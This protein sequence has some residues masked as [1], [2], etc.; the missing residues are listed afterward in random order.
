MWTPALGRKVGK[1]IMGEN[2][3][4]VK[5][6]SEKLKSL[7]A[8]R[9]LSCAPLAII[10]ILILIST[11]SSVSFNF[12]AASRF[13]Q[14]MNYTMMHVMGTLV[15]LLTIPS[16]ICLVIAL[17]FL[18]CARKKV[19]KKTLPFIVFCVIGMAFSALFS[20]LLFYFMRGFESTTGQLEKLSKISEIEEFVLTDDSEEGGFHDGIMYN[21]LDLYLTRDRFLQVS[22]MSEY[23]T[24]FYLNAAGD[25]N[26]FFVYEDSDKELIKQP[27]LKQKKLSELCGKKIKKLTDLISCYDTLMQKI[28]AMPI[29]EENPTRTGFFKKPLQKE[30]F[31]LREDDIYKDLLNQSG[32]VSVKKIRGYYEYLENYW[33]E[34][35]MDDGHALLMTVSAV[36]P[37]DDG[38]I[39]CYFSIRNFDS[40][41]I[42]LLSMTNTT[43]G[44][45]YYSPYSSGAFAKKVGVKMNS[46]RDFFPH[47]KEFL[48]LTDELLEESKKAKND[49]N[50]NKSSGM[51]S[52]TYSPQ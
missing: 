42:S 46:Y 6:T 12:N 41:S 19:G 32:V 29:L 17:V 27:W 7:I 34:I 36:F 20:V 43:Y 21:D 1:K 18:I 40:E 33:Y 37:Q 35:K 22:H 39:E 13:S 48:E 5:Q 31:A 30:K 11:L 52:G 50:R 24:S 28:E 45:N 44:I 14:I 9:I 49:K 47:Y 4:L 10:L 26:L 15:F 23:M 51:I 8:G 16:F 25:W 2:E 38:S 3:T